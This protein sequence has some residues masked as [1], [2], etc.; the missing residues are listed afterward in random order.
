M[1]E[2]GATM[3]TYRRHRCERNHRTRKTLTKCMFPRAVWILGNGPIALI[4][5]CRRPSITLWKDHAEA[6][7]SKSFIDRTGCGG[8][9]TGRHEIVR[10]ADPA[11][12]IGD[13]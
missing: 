1:P 7:G 10:I 13:A 11:E 5:W 12:A 6:L 2:N 8:G 4:A 9:C 3:K